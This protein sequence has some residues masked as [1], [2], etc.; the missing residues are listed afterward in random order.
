MRSSPFGQITRWVL[1]GERRSIAVWALAVASVSGFYAVF[2]GVFSD[3]NDLAALID[4]LP[5]GVVTALG[6]DQI[7]TAAGYLDSTVYSMLAPIM[8]SVFAIVFA[9]RVLPGAEERGDLELEFAAPV[10]RTQI[11]RERALAVVLAVLTVSLSVWI[12]ISVVVVSIGM[13]VALGYVAA[14]TFGLFLYGLSIAMITVAVGVAFGRR[15]LALGVGAGVAVVGFVF[16]A[17]APLV[18]AAT[19]L[20]WVSPFAWYVGANALREGIDGFAY[21]GLAVLSAAVFFAS[22]RRFVRRDLGV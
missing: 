10:S 8:L 14:A 3:L 18:D 20:T 5:E 2:W 6:Y 19:W 7:A 17:V 9:G 13:D 21:G 22:G 15:S 4:G 11:L 1:L 16:N 12:V